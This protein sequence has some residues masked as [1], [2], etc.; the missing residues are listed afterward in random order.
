MK[1]FRIVLALSLC[2][3]LMACSVDQVL[4]DIDLAVQMSG[5]IATAI[6]AISPA[7]AAL[8]QVAINDATV[9]L[10]V[11]KNDY[12]TWKASGATGDLAKLQQAITTLQ[13]NLPQELA[14]AHITNPA[15]VAK[16]NAWANLVTTSLDAVLQLIPQI[17]TSQASSYSYGMSM[18]AAAKA[19]PTP[20][21]LKARWDNEVCKADTNCKNLVKVHKVKAAKK[22]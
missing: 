4:T 18:F 16:A 11:I 17:Q 8:L 15:S 10:Q 14:A 12:D 13:T 20:A 19:I 21:S 22:K 5:S 6:S 1:K 3:F 9:G 7:D 2:L